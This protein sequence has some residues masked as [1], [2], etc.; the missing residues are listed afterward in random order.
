MHVKWASHK[1]TP[2]QSLIFCSSSNSEIIRYVGARTPGGQVAAAKFLWWQ[3]ILWVL[4]YVTC[5][6]SPSCA[7]RILRWFLAF[8]RSCVP[9]SLLL[10]NVF[11]F[12]YCICTVHVIRSLYCQYQH[13]HNLNVTG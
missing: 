2:N 4:H 13:M 3:L 6:I 9:V 8:M 1:Q 10:R 11:N 12:H 7:L 5:F